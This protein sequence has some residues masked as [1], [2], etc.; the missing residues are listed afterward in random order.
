M[1]QLLKPDVRDV[2]KFSM[3]E[4]KRNRIL[5]LGLAILLGILVKIFCLEVFT[6]QGNSMEPS[7][8]N[9]ET[10][11]VNKLAY[12]LQL[13]FKAKLLIP[14]KAPELHDVVIYAIDGNVIVKRITGLPGTPL[15][16]TTDSQ[17]NIVLNAE[18]IPITEVQYHKLSVTDSI[19]GGVYFATGDNPEKSIDSRD[20]GYIPQNNIL[21]RVLFK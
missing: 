4:K 15:E 21:G 14:W 9:G 5:A 13:P 12:G 19:P 1:N 11:I 17:Y 3:E 10:I 20:Y 16:F 18:K 8:K 2:D 6:V 7:I